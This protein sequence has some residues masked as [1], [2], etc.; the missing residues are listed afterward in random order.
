MRVMQLVRDHSRAKISDG[1][2]SL[3]LVSSGVEFLPALKMAKR[4]GCTV[5]LLHCPSCPQELRE[6]ADWAC[7][8]LTFQ[9]LSLEADMSDCDALRHSEISE[10]PSTP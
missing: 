10:G 2:G 6:Q 7:D 4:A 5:K 9:H 3:V 8:W 1:S